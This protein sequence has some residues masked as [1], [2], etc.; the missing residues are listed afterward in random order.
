MYGTIP[1]QAVEEEV[2]IYTHQAMVHKFAQ[3]LDEITG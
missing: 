3:V 1:Y 2:Q